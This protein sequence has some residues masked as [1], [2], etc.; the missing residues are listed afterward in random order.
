M[1]VCIEVERQTLRLHLSY[2][3]YI[4]MYVHHLLYFID[5]LL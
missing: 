5:L 3:C 1:V 4:Y 2:M